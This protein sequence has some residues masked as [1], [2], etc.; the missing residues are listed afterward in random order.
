MNVH[1]TCPRA[2]LTNLPG[3]HSAHFGESIAI[4]S[5]SIL[6]TGLQQPRGWLFS[7]H[8]FTANRKNSA[9]TADREPLGSGFQQPRSPPPLGW[10][11]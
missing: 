3:R 1:D 4:S 9:S 7:G 6:V 2:A 11:D 10:A 8:R 5:A